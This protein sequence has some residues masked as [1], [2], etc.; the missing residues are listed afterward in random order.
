MC[1]AGQEDVD[2]TATTLEPAHKSSLY[3]A[4]NQH[5]QVPLQHVVVSAAGPFFPDELAAHEASHFRM[6]HGCKQCI[7]LACK[8]KQLATASRLPVPSSPAVSQGRALESHAPQNITRREG[9]P[10]RSDLRMH[11]QLLCWLCNRGPPSVHVHSQVKA[12]SC[13]ATTNHLQRRPDLTCIC[14]CRITCLSAHPVHVHVDS[15]VK[16]GSVSLAASCLA[17]ISFMKGGGS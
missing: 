17:T 14:K 8:R 9:L 16:A 5:Q 13:L 2:C 4:N 11:E 6:T 1:W 12:A 3:P 10:E 7:A 15:Q